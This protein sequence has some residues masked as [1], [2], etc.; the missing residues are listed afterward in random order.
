MELAG[1]PD[2]KGKLSNWKL[3]PHAPKKIR[4]SETEFN[5]KIK[6][7]LFRRRPRLQDIVFLAVFWPERRADLLAE[8]YGEQP[9]QCKAFDSGPAVD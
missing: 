2:Q 6:L 3:E 8:S 4:C 9:V 7:E 1:K 5:R